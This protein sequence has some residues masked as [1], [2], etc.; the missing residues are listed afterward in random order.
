[1]DTSWLLSGLAV[2]FTIYG[3]L[4]ES[5]KRNIQYIIDYSDILL[6]IYVWF[7]VFFAIIYENIFEAA[8]K[9]L[10]NIIGI[11]S[12]NNPLSALGYIM[13]TFLGIN[14]YNKFK[15][16][17]I[18]DFDGFIANLKKQ[19]NKKQYNI[20]LEDLN[21]YGRFGNSKDK[22]PKLIGNIFNFLVKLKFIRPL[23]YR[24]NVIDF[25]NVTTSDLDYVSEMGKKY[26]ELAYKLLN[27]NIDFDKFTF[28]KNYGRYLIEDKSSDLYGDIR[29]I[30]KKN[31]LSHHEDYYGSI[32]VPASI[33]Y[34]NSNLLK[35][36]FNTTADIGGTL[37]AP[38]SG[39]A[40]NYLNKENRESNDDPDYLRW[41]YH[42]TPLYASIRFIELYIME[43]IFQNKI[44]IVEIRDFERYVHNIVKNIEESNRF[45]YPQFKKIHIIYLELIFAIYLKWIV[46]S[47]Y[48][49]DDFTSKDERIRPL[50]MDIIESMLSSYMFVRGSKVDKK[51]KM[52]INGIL[53][54][55]IPAINNLND[56]TKILKYFEFYED[57]IF[58]LFIIS[59]ED[60]EF[61]KN[62]SKEQRI[63]HLLTVIS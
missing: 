7:L 6:A 53:R 8:S 23:R 26:P 19:Y 36:L 50:I 24:R 32:D 56:N 5:K 21:N 28:W 49:I 2:F 60:K 52:E 55:T 27:T 44:G 43:C 39:F 14:V 34:G 51:I 33:D 17:G 3:L 9:L 22:P 62:K 45:H 48:Y 58:D 61:I 35:R 57:C 15:K 31:H 4:D 42:E 12:P 47:K 38:I 1:M 20:V 59:E 10:F 13:F 54:D 18:N 63:L 30:S 25:L 41:E 29:E 16:T 11:S 46:M 37:T 40:N